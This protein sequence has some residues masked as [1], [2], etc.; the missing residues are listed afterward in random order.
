MSSR[1]SRILRHQR[2]EPF[3]WDRTPAADEPTPRPGPA[4]EDR[5][6]VAPQATAELE[7]QTFAAAY[8]EG[9]KAGFEAGA[10]R[11]DAMLRR[12]GDTVRELGELRSTLS[13]QAERQVVQVALAIARRI[14]QREVDTDPDLLSAMARV[15]LDRLGDG[16]AIRIRLNPEDHLGINDRHDFSRVGAPITVDSDPAVP[17]GGCLIESSLGFVD[18]GIDA[19]FRVIQDALAREAAVGRLEARHAS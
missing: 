19:Q 17:R 7:R 1:P 2:V 12:L 16:D 10:V 15:A 3:V 18:A 8:A 9:E 13:Q 11:A 6:D 14:L 4:R 5:A